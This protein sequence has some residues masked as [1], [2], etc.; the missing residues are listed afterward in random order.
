MSKQPSK[1]K[2]AAPALPFYSLSSQ[3]GRKRLPLLL[4]SGLDFDVVLECSRG[5]RELPSGISAALES[6]VR[7]WEDLPY[8][9]SCEYAVSERLL[10]V[11]R[12]LQKQGLRAAEFS[13]PQVPDR[14]GAM[15]PRYFFIETDTTVDCADR[16]R[17]MEHRGFGKLSYRHFFLD[18]ARVPP[19]CHLF[20]P[21]GC[22]HL[23]ISHAVREEAE[24]LELSGLDYTPPDYGVLEW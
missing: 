7:K 10:G 1:N 23:V 24:R 21:A 17:S 12:H 19:D 18:P 5:N 9:I 11:L 4:N 22:A 3:R 15:P 16:E 8:M 6:P 20:R 14:Q 13:V 2:R